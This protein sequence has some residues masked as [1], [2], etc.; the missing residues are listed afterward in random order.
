MGFVKMKNDQGQVISV[1]EDYLDKYTGQGYTTDLQKPLDYD[2]LSANS[3][4]RKENEQY[5]KDAIVP[6]QDIVK[7]GVVTTMGTQKANAPAANAPAVNGLDSAYDQLNKAK[8]DSSI[9]ALGKSKD[10][11]LS[12]ISAQ[13]AEIKPNFYN[14]G[15]QARSTSGNQSRSF[16]EYLAQ[17]GLQSSGVAAQGEMN[18]MGAL[19]GTLGNL[20]TQEATAFAGIARD[21]ANVLNNY[22]SDVAGAK[23]G[24]NAQS[25]QDYINQSNRNQDIQLQQTS[26]DYNRQQATENTDYNRLQNTKGEYADTISQFYNNYQAEINKV[27]NDGD[28]TNDWQISMLTAARQQKIRELEEIENA[29]KAATAEARA[30]QDQIDFENEL[31]RSKAEYDIN[32]PYYAPKSSGSSG[33]SGGSSGGGADYGLNW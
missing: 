18:R 14:A 17:R 32:K 5:T 24:M 20:G 11:A 22:E 3:I 29:Q 12:N 7:S 25:L 26:L 19:Q 2:K 4:Y 31:K 27:Q 1:N 28:P 9:A 10:N 8:Y 21:K 16:S 6:Q 15:L 30:K 33:G 23:A 13:E